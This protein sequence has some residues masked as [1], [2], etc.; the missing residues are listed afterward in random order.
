MMSNAT[1]SAFKE[2]IYKVYVSMVIKKK[3]IDYLI[4][5]LLNKHKY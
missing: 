3:I 4:K 5:Y 2:L 1:S